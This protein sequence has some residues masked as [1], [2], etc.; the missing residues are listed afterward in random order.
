[1]G[2]VLTPEL[3][4]FLDSDPRTEMYYDLVTAEFENETIRAAFAPFD[5]VYNGHT[6]TGTGPFVSMSEVKE[7]SEHTIESMSLEASAI[8]RFDGDDSMIATV[9]DTNFVNRPVT[10]TRVFMESESWMDILGGRIIFDGFIKKASIKDGDKTDSK[11]TFVIQFQI[12]SFFSDFNRT[13]GRKTDDGSHQ[14]LYPGDR[15]FQTASK[16]AKEIQWKTP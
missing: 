4:A 2:V 1:M 14:A 12:A 3:Q 11:S 13:N 16:V 15:F 6:H 10:I 8:P 7:T 9:L 5:I